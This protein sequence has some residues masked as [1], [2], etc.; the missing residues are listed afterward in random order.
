MHPLAHHLGED[1][2]VNLLGDVNH[3]HINGMQ[4]VRGS[5][6]L[7]STTGQRP[8][9]RSTARESRRSRSNFAATAYAPGA[10]VA[11]EAV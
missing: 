2:L 4:G 1:S 3:P 10:A 5:N 9:L 11:S 6:P 8:S 7:G